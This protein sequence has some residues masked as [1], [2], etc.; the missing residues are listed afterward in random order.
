MSY[1][2]Y[3]KYEGEKVTTAPSGFGNWLAGTIILVEKDSLTLEFEVRK[4]MTNP[5]NMLHGGMIAAIMDEM[6]GMTIYVNDPSTFFYSINLSVDF[7]NNVTVGNTV[8]AKT[9]LYKKSNRLIQAECSIYGP[10]GQLL[11]KG[12]SNLIS[13]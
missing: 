7:V 9:N 2:D 5:V 12:T 1:E 4:E 3:K 11:A 8:T 6:I 10:M 13:K